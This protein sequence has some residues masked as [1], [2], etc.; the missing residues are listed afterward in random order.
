[1]CVCVFTSAHKE[2]IWALSA[3]RHEFVSADNE[4]SII[5]WTVKE[6]AGEDAETVVEKRIA[7]SGIGSVLPTL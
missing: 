3:F 4:G 1:V 6:D 2:S 7:I 5:L